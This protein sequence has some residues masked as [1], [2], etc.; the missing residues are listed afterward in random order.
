MKAASSSAASAAL[1]EAQMDMAESSIPDSKKQRMLAGLF[2]CV[3][4]SVEGG[5][6]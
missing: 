2:V 6:P 5:Y 1:E 3:L 4:S